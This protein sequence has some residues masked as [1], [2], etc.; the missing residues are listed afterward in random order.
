MVTPVELVKG[1]KCNGEGLKEIGF[2]KDQYYGGPT[3][4]G[5]DN[6]YHC[7]GSPGNCAVVAVNMNGCGLESVPKELSMFGHRFL[8][9]V[10][11]RNN[12]IKKIENLENHYVLGTL[13]LD[14]NQI[15]TFDGLESL[16][17]LKEIDLSGNKITKIGN[18]IPSESGPHSNLHTLN[19][20]KNPLQKDECKN[21]KKETPKW[22]ELLC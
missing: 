12:K 22:K 15:E 21:A 13:L 11:L 20:K 1:M 17:S 2:R 14:G 5:G 10:S 18:F 19:L 6:G 9:W 8:E 7:D 16:E 3:I 4:L